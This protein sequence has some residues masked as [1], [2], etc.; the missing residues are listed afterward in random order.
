MLMM[1]SHFMMV[2]IPYRTMTHSDSKLLIQIQHSI[3]KTFGLWDGLDN[4][5]LKIKQAKEFVEKSLNL[6]STKY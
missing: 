1:W 6:P 3:E 2:L 5:Q 4:P